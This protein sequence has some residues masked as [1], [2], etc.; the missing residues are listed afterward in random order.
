MY[1]RQ[2]WARLMRRVLTDRG[3]QLLRS[4]PHNGVEE[5][6][7]AVASCLHQFRGITVSPEQVVVG[8]GTEYLYGLIVQLLGR[9]LSY[10][11]VSYTH[12]DVYKRQVPEDR[13]AGHLS[14]GGSAGVHL[15][16]P[17]ARRGGSCL[18]YT[19]PPTSSPSPTDRSI[20]RPICSLPDSG[21]R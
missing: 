20:W 21:R 14:G 8:A 12:L 6:R 7:R 3:E 10:G 9:D 4:S 5:L 19:S 1:K 18:L 17:G 16:H 2:V 11:A 13:G 15:P